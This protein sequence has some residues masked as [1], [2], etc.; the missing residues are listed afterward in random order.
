MNRT[1]NIDR[2]AREY[3]F[4]KRETRERVNSSALRSN[5]LLDSER[6]KDS[7][8]FELRGQNSKRKKTGANVVYSYR[9]ENIFYVYIYINIYTYRSYSVHAIG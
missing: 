3:I 7:T 9:Q 1:E 2:R 8:R 4:T 6:L 5:D